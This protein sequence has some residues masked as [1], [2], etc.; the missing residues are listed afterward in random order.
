MFLVARRISLSW[1]LHGQTKIKMSLESLP[2]LGWETTLVN[3]WL[4]GM[5]AEHYCLSSCFRVVVLSTGKQRE[6]FVRR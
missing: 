4:G 2:G 1:M 5:A 3:H 6:L